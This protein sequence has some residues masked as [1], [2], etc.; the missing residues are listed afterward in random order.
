MVVA[1]CLLVEAQVH[2]R[3]WSKIMCA[4]VYLK[5]R[6]L[7]NTIEKKTPYEI[8]F[9]RKPNV[10][11]LRLHGSKI[12]VRRPEQKQ[13][14]KFETKVDTGILLGYNKTRLFGYDCMKRVLSG[15][16]EVR[17]SCECGRNL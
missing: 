3:Y 4:A 13:I 10:T 16:E 8:F 9:K 11:N 14:C 1:R 6:T 5:N 17:W 12:F 7:T 2:K 15:G